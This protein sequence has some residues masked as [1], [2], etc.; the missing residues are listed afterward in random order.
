MDADLK[1]VYL[2]ITQAQF[3]EDVFGYENIILPAPTL[4]EFL[5]ERYDGLRT[6]TDPRQYSNPDDIEAARDA[7]TLLDRFYE[8]AKR[9]IEEY[10]YGIPGYDRVAAPRG[11]KTFQIGASVF[12]VGRKLT[13]GDHTTL[14]GAFMERKM[15]SVRESVGDVVVKI[16]KC[17]EHNDHARNEARI[18]SAL[19]KR[20]VPQWKHLPFVL[21][22]FQSGGR[23]GSVQRL[24]D[25]YTLTQVR[26]HDRHRKGVDRK[27]VAWMIDRITSCFGYVHSQGIVHGNL[28]PDHL[29]VQPHNHNVIV[30]GW[31]SAVQDPARSGERV[32]EAAAVFAA[33]EV[34][35]GGQ[36]GPW[37]DV[38]SIGK[39][40]IWLLGGDPEENS[41]PDRVEEPVQDFLLRLVAESP[42]SRPDDCWELYDE[43]CHIKDSLWPRKFLHFDM[44]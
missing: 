38:Y 19:H 21:G 27:H 40:L 36:I 31:G 10:V 41:I 13:Q 14:Y 16:A 24:V 35:Q 42:T 9:R 11:G 17:D 23:V 1:D 15:D 39:T 33:P 25:G 34:T 4:L 30:C 26:Q 8:Q 29:M 20:E 44:G 6:V 7:T 22:S 18:L 37:S 5:A 28:T 3:P 12:S 43:Q 32:R 2:R